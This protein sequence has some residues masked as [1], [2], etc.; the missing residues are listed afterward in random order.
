MTSRQSAGPLDLSASPH[1][2]LRPVPVSSVRLEG[3]FWGDRFERVR[4]VSLPGQWAQLEA[5]GVLDNFRRLTN[6]SDAPHQGYVFADTDLYKWL[7]AASWVLC[8]ERDPGLER[9]VDEG[10]TLVERAQQPDGYLHTYYAR[11]RAL[12]RFTNLR[13]SHET[14]SAGHLIQAAIAHWRTTGSGRLLDVARRFADL[15][16]QTFGPAESGRRAGIDGHAEVEL[17]LVELYRATGER[18]YLEQASYFVEARGHGLLTEG[19]FGREYFQD[20]L[21][22]RELDSMSGHAVRALYYCCGVSDLYLET[23]DPSLL[24]TLSSLFDRMVARR[25][26]VTGGLGARHEGEA[27]GEDFELPNARAYTETCAAVGSIMWSHRM[28]AATGQARYADLLET[29]LYNALLPGWSLDGRE[30]FYVNPLQDDGSHR[31]RPWY[32]C[33]CCPP[34][35]AR[36]VAS[37]GGYL[38]GTDGDD[39][40]YVHQ[41]VQSSARVLIRE[42][43]VELVQRTRYPWEGRVELEVRG[44][45]DFA[46]FLRIPAWCTSA[47][48]LL[49]NGAAVT[50]ALAPGSYAEVRRSWKPGDRVELAMEM[51]VRV[52]ESHPHLMENTGRVS[53][54]RGP[55]VYCV[56]GADH[57]DVDLLGLEI[58]PL[59][60]PRAAWDADALGGAVVLRGE[61]EL[62]EL[63]PSWDGTLYRPAAEPS[64]APSRAISLT[65]I[66]Y[67]AFANRAAGQLQVWLRRRSG[68]SGVDPSRGA[69]AV[70]PIAVR[71]S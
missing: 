66:P 34:N 46:L 68:S 38:Y 41:Y 62:R 4:S 27:F 22:F 18:R 1:A 20:H 64:P 31:R 63:D 48:S 60:P 71:R 33:A 52:L 45:G 7:E 3:Q 10:S 6:G 2:R 9:L 14:Y 29:T 40:L 44:E 43:P 59:R 51:P 49:V 5:S 26:Y 69:H 70:E 28:L 13:D 15:L 8:Q 57:P 30:Y 16:C 24:R 53:L 55:L 21:P 56:E 32:K 12:N 67:F 54:A 50:T 58:D 61:A 35:V 36:T 11:D 19:I 17:A 37:L 65:A 25:T 39:G 42:R 47:P 23:G